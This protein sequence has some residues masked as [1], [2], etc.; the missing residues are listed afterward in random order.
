MMLFRLGL[1]ELAVRKK[2]VNLIPL[3]ARR[4]IFGVLT[5]LFP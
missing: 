1:Q 3:L 2:L 5:S 4:S